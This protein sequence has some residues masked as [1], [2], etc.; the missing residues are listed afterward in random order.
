MYICIYIYIYTYTHV[1][2][3]IRLYTTTLNAALGEG[4]CSRGPSAK[5]RA[6]ASP[7]AGVYQ[8][9]LLQLNILQYGYIQIQIVYIYIYTYIYIYREREREIMLSRR[10][11]LASSRG[12]S[13]SSMLPCDS[14]FIKNNYLKR[15]RCLQNSPW[16][17]TGY[18]YIYIYIYIYI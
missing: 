12:I 7:A 2:T 10:S 17:T 13:H 14:S 5:G 6:T 15:K 1:Y 4:P 11:G 3:H 9:S 16:W 8:H 18:T